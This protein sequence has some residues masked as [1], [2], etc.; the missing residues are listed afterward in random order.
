MASGALGKS[1]VY[2]NWRGI[3]WARA[4]RIP[5]NPRTPAQQA[6]RALQAL[7]VSLWKGLA[8]KIKGA[9]NVMA[10]VA[11]ASTGVG[12]KAATKMSGYNL[13]VGLT[14]R[15]TRYPSELSVCGLTVNV[16]N[17]LTFAVTP[18]PGATPAN[19]QVHYAAAPWSKWQ[20][21]TG[22]YS[23]A[24]LVYNV[25][26]P[27][28]DLPVGVTADEIALVVDAN[29]NATGAKVFLASNFTDGKLVQNMACP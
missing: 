14:R 2:G 10:E 11:R 12:G 8:P 13:F 18:G 5:Q 27:F 1:V 4:Y 26:A 25:P 15:S 16:D 17:S 19:V 29:D 7:A 9:Y 21:A 23:G 20:R 6:V 28:V 3:A 24:G 22:T